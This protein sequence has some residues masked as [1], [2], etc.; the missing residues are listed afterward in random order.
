M[1]KISQNKISDWGY[2]NRQTKHF[3]LTGNR[4]LNFKYSKEKFISEK[5]SLN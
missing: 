2:L 5:R 3:I 4:N 1:Y